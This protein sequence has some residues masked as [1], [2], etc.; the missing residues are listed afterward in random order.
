MT[1]RKQQD[2]KGFTLDANGKYK[3]DFTRDHTVDGNCAT[4]LKAY[5]V[6]LQK[7]VS[8][9]EAALKSESFAVLAQRALLSETTRPFLG[10]W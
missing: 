4:A 3:L 10:S 6:V 1:S 5:Q 7:E 2:N 9:A 8:D